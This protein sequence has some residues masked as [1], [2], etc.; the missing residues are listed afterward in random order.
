MSRIRKYAVRMHQTSITPCTLTSGI[1]ITGQRRERFARH[2]HDRPFVHRF[3]AKPFVKPDG[4]YVPVQHGPFKAPASPGDRQSSHLREKRRAVAPAAPGG[5][6][7]Q[8]PTS[9]ADKPTVQVLQP[10]NRRPAQNCFAALFAALPRF[11]CATLQVIM[12]RQT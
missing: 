4:V 6:L 2:T 12:Q 1:R 11:A 9:I 8:S 5:G 7:P 3:G 10:V